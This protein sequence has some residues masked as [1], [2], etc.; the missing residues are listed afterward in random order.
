MD[1]QAALAKIAEEVSTNALVF[2]VVNDETFSEAGNILVNIAAAKKRIA[3]FFEKAI[4]TAHLAHKNVLELKK[5]AEAPLL[6]AEAHLRKEG[7]LYLQKKQLEVDEL[8]SKLRIQAEDAQIKMAEE[9]TAQGLG[10]VAESILET[11]VTLPSIPLAPDIDGIGTRKNLKIEVFDLKA[12]ARAVADSRIPVQA[13]DANEQFIK[14]E[15]RRK[16]SLFSCPGIRVY[17]ETGITVGGRK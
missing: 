15:A 11:P 9:A 14:Q 3:D 13:I 7:N 10:E 17:F 4:R 1:E 12:L 8:E 5:I 16:G 2:S 6:E